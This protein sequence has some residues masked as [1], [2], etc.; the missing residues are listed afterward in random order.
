MARGFAAGGVQGGR[1]GLR[2]QLLLAAGTLLFGGGLVVRLV[3]KPLA[4]TALR[5]AGL[6]TIVG[7]IWLAVGA[8]AH[9]LSR[10]AVAGRRLGRCGCGGGGALLFLVAIPCI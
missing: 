1:G 4:G 8:P 6:P 9:S 10:G 7:G 3:G 5:L 2:T